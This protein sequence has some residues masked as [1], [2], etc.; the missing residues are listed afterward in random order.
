M[1]LASD[2]VTLGG[3]NGGV[4][5]EEGMSGKVVLEVRLREKN[6]VVSWWGNDLSE[7]SPVVSL[8]PPPML[9]MLPIVEG[10]II[11]GSDLN[12]ARPVIKGSIIEIISTH[13]SRR[14]VRLLSDVIQNVLSLEERD[15]AANFSSRKGRGRLRKKATS[16][17]IIANISLCDSNLRN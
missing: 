17:S 16:S 7:G 1:P 5:R 11:E 2:G 12:I 15:L 14:K 6:D 13:G 4:M 8:P 3:L 9:D 10:A